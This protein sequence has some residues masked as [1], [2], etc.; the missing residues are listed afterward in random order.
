M[1]D[2]AGEPHD[3][4]DSLRLFIV[5][6]ASPDSDTSWSDRGV[7]NVNKLLYY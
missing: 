7:K 6:S 5:S 3:Y 4:D 1:L 2:P